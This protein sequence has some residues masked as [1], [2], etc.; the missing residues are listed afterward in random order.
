MKYFAAVL[1]AGLV[2]PVAAA[3]KLTP[4]DR[5]EIIR[6]LAAEY[7]TV[8]AFLPRSKKALEFNSDGS[9]D[10]TAWE[11]AGREM[12][13]AARVGDLVQIT[14]VEIESDKILLEINGG[15]KSGRKWY[16]RVEVGMGTRTTPIGQGGTP[17]AGTNI[18][19][20]FKKGVPPL[21]SKEFKKML[22][23]VLDFEKRSAS[24]SYVESLPPEIQAAV[25]EKRVVEGMNKDQVL[26]AVGKPRNK[27]RE[28]K[29]GVELE[30]W[31]YGMPPGKITFVTFDGNKVVK[32]KDSWAGLGGTTAEPLKPHD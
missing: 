24:E 31:V 16:E 17:T 11:E 3:E 20:V 27:M 10:K 8:K 25:K 28:S 26:L 13:P 32:V 22:S 6:G 12:G 14:K 29:D 1:I 15:V 18:A 23:P 5:M 7:A 9:Y 30:D 2:F 21:E 19:L 4:E